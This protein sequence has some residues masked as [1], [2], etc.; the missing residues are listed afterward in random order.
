MPGREPPF[1]SVAVIGLG[2]IGG[3]IAAAARRAWPDIRVVGVDASEE[4]ARAASARWVAD[5]ATTDLAAVS[6]AELVIMAA[7]VREN[8]AMLE[9]LTSVVRAPAV[10]TDVGSTKRGI[11]EAAAL[12]FAAGRGVVFIGGHP[13][14]GAATGGLEAA[15]ADLFIDKPWIFTPGGGAPAGA[16][17]RLFAFAAGLGARPASM[18]AVEHDRLVA[19]I[20]HLPQLAASVL[21]QVV[22]NAVGTE[23]LEFAGPGLVDTTRLADS[24]PGIWTDICATNADNIRAALAAL[25]AALSS[26]DAHLADADHLTRA[27]AAAHTF[28]AAL[29]QRPR[30]AGRRGQQGQQGREG[31]E[32]RGGQESGA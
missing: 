11:V 16:V 23:G 26:M 28:R 21:M 3:S 24:L 17:D 6:G 13:M 12:A 5:V 25:A 20:S 4:V 2:L 32:G 19:F 30:Q 22:G 10:V 29:G 27:F 15:R 8:V 9:C 31:R 14:A 7:P 18:T 1:A